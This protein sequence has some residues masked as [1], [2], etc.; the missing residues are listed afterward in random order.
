[1]NNQ[2]AWCDTRPESMVRIF[3]RIDQIKDVKYKKT[4]KVPSIKF[5]L[6]KYGLK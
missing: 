4:I 2:T 5:E 6:K 1:M 3:D